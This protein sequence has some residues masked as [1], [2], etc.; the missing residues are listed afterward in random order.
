MVE[1]SVI[2]LVGQLV[3]VDQKICSNLLYFYLRLNTPERIIRTSNIYQYYITSPFSPSISAIACNFFLC[4]DNNLASFRVSRSCNF[5][6]SLLLRVSRYWFLSKDSR[7]ISCCSSAT[8]G[9]G[10]SLFLD[11]SI[12]V[13]VL[14]FVYASSIRSGTIRFRSESGVAKGKTQMS[15]LR[16]EH[17]VH[18]PHFPR[19]SSL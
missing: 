6:M 3:S 1:R 18:V 19:S 14:G 15:E 5:K 9:T 12:V 10:I 8:R 7:S 11:S 13:A 16:K 2:V 17:I 4:F